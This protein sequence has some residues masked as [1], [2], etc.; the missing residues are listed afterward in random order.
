MTR[1]AWSVGVIACSTLIFPASRVAEACSLPKPPAALKGIPADGE[2]GVA[3]NVRP[4]YDTLAAD[5]AGSVNDARFELL[6]ASGV[7]IAVAARATHQWHFELFPAVELE[8]QTTYTLHASWTTNELNPV[9]FTQSFTTGAGPVVGAPAPPVASLRHYRVH[10]PTPVSCGTAYPTGTCVSVNAGTLVQ[11]SHIDDLGQEHGVHDENGVLTGGY[12]HGGPFFANLSGI[13][14]GT[15]FECVR[16]RSRGVDGSLSAPVTLCRDD[17]PLYELAG[18]AM[19][20]CTSDGLTRGGALVL[21][22]DPISSGG[23]SVAG[24]GAPSAAWFMLA[25]VAAALRRATAR[26]SRS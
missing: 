8:P 15:N 19:L 5:L 17:G 16:L 26:R 12:L 25:A 11:A 21:A 7:A 20:G 13:D 14:Q 9:S 10:E 22:S 18:G 3:T 23:C 4:V 2:T 24:E 6:S 1:R